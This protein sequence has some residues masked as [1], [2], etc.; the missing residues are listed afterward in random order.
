MKPC[1]TC[2]IVG[3]ILL[4]APFTARAQD[5]QVNGLL[6]V[7]SVIPSHDKSWLKGGLG[8]LDNG[9]GGGQSPAIVGQAMGDLRVQLDP[10]FSGF[11]TFRVAPDQHAPL[12]ILEAYARYQPISTPSWLA[13]V[14]LGAF[15]PPISL[16]NESIG[17]TSPWTLT[18][19]AINS[20]V[21]DELRTIGG[22]TNVEWRYGTGALGLTG[23]VFGWNDP[24][25]TV[26]ADRGWV[27]GSRP[28][29]LFGEPRRP[30]AVARQIRKAPPLRE[31]P[32]KEIDGEPGWYAGA[33]LRQDELGRL[34]ALY[35][36]NRADPAAFIGSDFGWR[37]KFTSVGLETYIGD[38]VVLGQAMAG[39]TEIDPIANLRNITD[40]QSVYVLAGYYFGE[41][42]VAA[43]VDVFA[44]QQYNNRGRSGPGE[45]GRALTLSGSWSPIRWF[46]LS[47]ELLHVD[48]YS[49]Q[50]AAAG[51]SPNASELQAQLVA[52]IFF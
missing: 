29:G 35:Y 33:S 40:F 25:G 13:S 39:Q 24:A 32:F 38:V 16:E 15:F 27:F 45:H 9:G 28:I 5:V 43:R 21:G 8:K 30:D 17:W 18:P 34:T 7:G 41:F 36:D 1:A 12:D 44:T 26:L 22:E 31:Q 14:K 37:T 48:S 19:S 2:L 49:G 10:S 20:W 50:R 47:T 46:R 42:R 3:V 51:M 52:R 6:D 23:A 11:A 4:A